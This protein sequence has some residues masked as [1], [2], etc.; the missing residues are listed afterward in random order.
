MASRLV[1]LAALVVAGRAFAQTSGDAEPNVVSASLEL[2]APAG[3]GSDQELARA[4]RARSERI[5][6]DATSARRL[7]IE[8]RDGGSIVT[9]VLSLTEPNGR[10]S[11]RTLRAGRA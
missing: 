3:C 10:R 8:L 9:T 6:I 11:T 4:I 7:R 2:V 1:W 5:R